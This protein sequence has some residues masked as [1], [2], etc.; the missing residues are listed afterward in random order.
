MMIHFWFQ[1][2]EIQHENM[3]GERFLLPLFDNDDELLAALG[4]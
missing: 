1:K 4:T 3:D 2:M